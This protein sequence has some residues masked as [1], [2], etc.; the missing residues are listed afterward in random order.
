[1]TSIAVPNE[2]V[3][4]IAVPNEIVPTI[5][6]P[7][8]IIAS[9][10]IIAQC[11]KC[12]KNKLYIS[13][14]LDLIIDPCAQNGE[15]VEGL[16]TLARNTLFYDKAPN[17]PHPHIREADFLTIDFAR[18]DKTFLSG[19]WYDDIHVIGCPPPDQIGDFIKACCKFGQSVSFLLPYGPL[20][21]P[22]KD[23]KVYFPPNFQLLHEEKINN[24]PYVF[25]IWLKTDL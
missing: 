14:D 16:L 12:I 11:I 10:E 9:P 20:H 24:I 15:F 18:F 25:Q 5:V 3:P 17:N 8:N 19:L 6:A 7:H 2:I 1:M 4:N 21:L 22:K 13:Y 23:Y